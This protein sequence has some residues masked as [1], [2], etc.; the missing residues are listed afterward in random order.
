MTFSASTD[1]RKATK[2]E[3]IADGSPLFKLVL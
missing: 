1:K 2:F 3:G